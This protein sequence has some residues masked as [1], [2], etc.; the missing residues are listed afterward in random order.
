M[1]G[2]M[3]RR[4]AVRLAV[5]LTAVSTVLLLVASVLLVFNRGLDWGEV[6]GGAE[7]YT[8][9]FVV[10]G[11]AVVGLVLAV[12]RPGHRIGWL[13]IAMGLLAAVTAFVSEYALYAYVTAPG[14]L[15]AAAWL[16]WAAS[17]TWPLILPALAVLLLLFPDGRLPSPR[18]RVVPWLLGVSFG[19]VTIWTMLHP[20]A[21]DPGVGGQGLQPGTGCVLGRPA[22]RAARQCSRHP[23]RRHRD[24]RG[25]SIACWRRCFVCG[26]L[27]PP[28]ASSSSG[29][30][31]SPG[32][33]GWPLPRGLHCTGPR[34]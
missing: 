27:G 17:W 33:A 15:P 19:G 20:A 6:Y 32:A 1:V 34:I 10:P 25:G 21:M 16:A 24:C 9:A 11:F 31:L 28:S 12:R 7:V 18:W 3:S 14:S 30:P 26:G 23:G 29:W 8:Y 4:N 13:F 22:D 5:T 2:P